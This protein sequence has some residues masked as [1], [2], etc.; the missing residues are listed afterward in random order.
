MGKNKKDDAVGCCHVCAPLWSPVPSLSGQLC[1]QASATKTKV[2]RRTTPRCGDKWPDWKKRKRKR[3]FGCLDAVARTRHFALLCC[4]RKPNLKQCGVR[5]CCRCGVRA[6]PSNTASSQDLHSLVCQLP[7]ITTTI[8]QS[9]QEL[10][11]R[12]RHGSIVDP[13]AKHLGPLCRHVFG[14]RQI[15]LSPCGIN[16]KNRFNSTLILT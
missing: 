3:M 16:I 7:S 14:M 4:N 5:M 9:A 8:W 2:Q 13:V 1:K 12:S 15:E 6:T 11:N 10:G